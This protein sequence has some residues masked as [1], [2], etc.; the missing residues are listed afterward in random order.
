MNMTKIEISL[1]QEKADL[2]E[3]WANEEIRIAR[4]CVDADEADQHYIEATKC[5]SSASA[6]RNILVELGF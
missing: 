5:L 1:I 4:Q 6:L 2:F 3:N